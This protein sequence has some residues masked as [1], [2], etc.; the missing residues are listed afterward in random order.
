MNPWQI[1][2]NEAISEYHDDDVQEAQSLFQEAHDLADTPVDQARVKLWFAS[3]MRKIGQFEEA[4]IEL[5]G[6]EKAGLILLPGDQNRLDQIRADI[7]LGMQRF[8]EAFSIYNALLQRAETYDDLRYLDHLIHDAIYQFEDFQ[9]HGTVQN[10]KQ[11]L[12]EKLSKAMEFFSDITGDD[13]K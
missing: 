9:T 11:T 6:V 13:E 2:L 5:E 3:C 10:W 8:Q 4:L 12:Q 7:Y 1:K